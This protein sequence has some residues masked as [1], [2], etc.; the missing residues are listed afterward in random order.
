M[1]NHAKDINGLM[2]THAKRYAKE[3]CVNE[4]IICEGLLTLA[5]TRKAERYL[6]K[7]DDSEFMDSSFDMEGF[8]QH[9]S[10]CENEGL[11]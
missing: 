6:E 4:D 9:M 5:K 7:M 11:L 3:A 2:L 10:G 8:Q 1:F